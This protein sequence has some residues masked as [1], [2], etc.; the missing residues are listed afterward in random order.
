MYALNCKEKKN[1]NGIL[2][3]RQMMLVNILYI[4]I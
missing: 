1:R 3:I 4:D 2:G